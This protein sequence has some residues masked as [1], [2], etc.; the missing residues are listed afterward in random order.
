MNHGCMVDRKFLEQV[1][2]SRYQEI[3]GDDANRIPELSQNCETLACYLEPPFNRLVA[4][5]NAA[6]GQYLRFPFAR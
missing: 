1:K 6:H 3:L 4:I 2:V 5:G